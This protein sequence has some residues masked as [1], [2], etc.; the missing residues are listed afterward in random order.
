MAPLPW[1]FLYQVEMGV[2]V[3]DPQR[4]LKMVMESFQQRSGDRVVASQGDGERSRFQGL[5]HK[6]TGLVQGGQVVVSEHGRV[7]VIDNG[8]VVQA[9]NSPGFHVEKG[10]AFNSVQ[11]PPQCSA[12]PLRR[13]TC[14]G[15]ADWR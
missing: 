9:H 3:D 1:V 5:L 7:P 2:N 12:D 8:V 6:H 13:V 15:V 10:I 14:S 11:V 4:T